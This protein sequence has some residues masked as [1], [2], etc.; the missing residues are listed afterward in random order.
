MQPLSPGSRNPCGA[1]P[2]GTIAGW[3][4]LLCPRMIPRMSNENES[5][6]EAA[7]LRV[8]FMGLGIMGRA[9]AE[10]IL[11]GGWP[12]TVYNRSRDKTVILG[13]LGAR[14]ASTPRELA[15]ASDVV[16]CMLTGPQAVYALLT[17][18]DGCA[19]GLDKGKVFV[20]MGTV[21]PA[22]A[23]EI[24]SGLAPLG[25]TYVDAP[26]SGS[27]KPAEQGQLVIL[28]GGPEAVVQE[29]TPLF[30]AMGKQVVHCGDVGQGSMAKMAIN[31]LL[32]SMMESMGEM[33]A[34][35]RAGGL[36]DDVLFEVLTAGPLACGLFG[37]KEKMLREDY[38]PPQFPLKHMAKDLKYVLDTADEV[39]A[40]VP[41]AAAMQQ[42]YAAGR[43][44]GLGDMDFAAVAK[45]LAEL[46]GSKEG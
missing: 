26:V 22:Y 42:L 7:A 27:K 25:V 14:V 38:F 44:R 20:N 39:G 10:N 2:S 40:P 19:R 41:A 37:L 5:N 32:G 45:V 3:I 43:A 24:A 1:R 46:G 13:E 12:L 8:G 33:L 31:M 9:M 21:S 28:A 30:L 11:Q 16:I 29:L 17:G 35:G 36:S 4:K 34:L 6:N 15:E 18:E 23:R